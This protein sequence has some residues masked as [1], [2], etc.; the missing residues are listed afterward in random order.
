MGLIKKMRWKGR[1]KVI[2]RHF[3]CSIKVV[4]RLCKQGYVSEKWGVKWFL[5]KSSDNGSS[6]LLFIYWLNV[7]REGT[8]CKIKY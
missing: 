6:L 1:I 7:E 3:Q 5:S 4:E 8:K 2:K